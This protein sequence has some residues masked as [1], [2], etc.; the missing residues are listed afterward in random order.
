MGGYFFFYGGGVV[1]DGGGVRAE[2]SILRGRPLWRRMPTRIS[3]SLHNTIDGSIVY[4][5]QQILNI[6]LY[7]EL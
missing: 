6:N 3:E 1:E 4:H 5:D 7:T 2:C